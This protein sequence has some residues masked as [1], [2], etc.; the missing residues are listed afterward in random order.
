MSSPML[1]RFLGQWL[2]SHCADAKLKL[3]RMLGLP[4]ETGG[5]GGDRPSEESKPLRFR[6][7]VETPTGVPVAK[8]EVDHETTLGG[9]KAKVATSAPQFPG[10]IQQLYLAGH[11]ETGFLLTWAKKFGNVHRRELMAN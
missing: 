5:G 11:A 7:S 9:V 6:V 2:P 10:S 4:T 3:Q 1:A 8:F